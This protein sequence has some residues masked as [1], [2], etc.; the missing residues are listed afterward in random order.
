MSK[1]TD[2]RA[3]SLSSINQTWLSTTLLSELQEAIPTDEVKASSG[4]LPVGAV[5]LDAASPSGLWINPFYRIIRSA[6]TSIQ[7]TFETKEARNEIGKDAPKVYGQQEPTTLSYP[8]GARTEYPD[9]VIDSQKYR[10]Q[11][12]RREIFPDLTDP[13]KGVGGPRNMICPSNSAHNLWARGYFALRPDLKALTVQFY[14]QPRPSHH[15]FDSVDL[16]KYPLSSQNLN[17]IGGDYLVNE[18]AMFIKSGDTFTL[19][20]TDP[21]THPLPSFPLLEIQWHLSR[22]VSMSGAAEIFNHRYEDDDE[23]NDDYAVDNLSSKILP[24]IPLPPSSSSSSDDSG[25]HDGAGAVDRLSPKIPPSS[26][27]RTPMGRVHEPQGLKRWTVPT[28]PKDHDS[29]LR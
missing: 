6:P 9:P 24:W 8:M 16:L 12:W 7:P 14:W 13:E 26:G 23:Y 17:N 3:L 21:I 19:T 28:R 2:D 20:T 29:R 27:V 10:L 22:V 25:P 11:Q 15:R 4:Y 5:A 1:G 18:E